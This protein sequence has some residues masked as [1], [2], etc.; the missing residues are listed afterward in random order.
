MALVPLLQK[1]REPFLSLEDAEDISKRLAQCLID[2]TSAVVGSKLPTHEK[3]KYHS[4]DL[5]KAQ[6]EINTISKARDLIR[7]LYLNEVNT[8]EERRMVEDHLTVL[9][10]RL[11]VMGL[12]SVPRSLE[13]KQLHEW[14]ELNA[15]ADIIE[16]RDNGFGRKGTSKKI[17][18]QSQKPWPMV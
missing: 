4:S 12:R 9:L 17:V 1:A 2:T 8:Q 3:G 13:L 5:V 10:D 14:S 11:C 7:T 16:I 15:P 18:S 6:A